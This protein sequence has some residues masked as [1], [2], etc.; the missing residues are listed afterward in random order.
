MS[1]PFPLD[2]SLLSRTLAPPTARAALTALNRVEFIS[3]N[4][5]DFV[6]AQI[7]FSEAEKPSLHK[8]GR[9]KA[10][11]KLFRKYKEERERE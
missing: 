4:H 8:R 1:L 9:L 10:E 3:K 6:G 11:K 5:S 2:S 7:D